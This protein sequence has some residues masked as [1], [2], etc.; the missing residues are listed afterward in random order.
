MQKFYRNLLKKSYQIVK[1]YKFLW[2]FG[3]FAAIMG[4]G[5]EVQMLFRASDAIPNLPNNI[6]NLGNFLAANAPQ[7]LIY[8]T[9]FLIKVQPGVII[10]ILV[11]FL[12]IILFVV[13]MIVVSQAALV[14]SVDKIRS[15]KAVDLRNAFANTRSLAW[16]VF[17]LNFFTRFILYASLIILIL[18]FSALLVLNNNNTIGLFG[19]TLLAFVIA[20]P[21]AMIV[22]FILKYALVFVVV[23]KENVWSAFVKAFEL[24]RKNWFVSIETAV[25]MFFVNILMGLAVFLLIFFL[26]VPFLAL[27]V[28]LVGLGQLVLANISMLL[29]VALLIILIVWAGSIFAVFQYSLWTLLFFELKNGRAYPKLLRLAGKA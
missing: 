27:A 18:P 14:Y 26:A 23:E 8:N 22:N 6:N 5:G 19:I 25:I 21:L 10:P 1:R 24:F 17:L 7:D 4:N 15:N 11:L 16:P 28:L 2:F 12:A 9:W 3:V 13:W 20:V 29:V